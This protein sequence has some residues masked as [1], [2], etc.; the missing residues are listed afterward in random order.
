M[1]Q[2]AIVAVVVAAM[3]ATAGCASQVTPG[4]ENGGNGAS[5][6]VYISD[7]PNAIGDFEHLNVTVSKVGVHRVDD[8]DTEADE[9]GWVEKDVGN[10][11]VDLTQLTGTKAVKLTDVGLENGTYDKVFIHVSAVN[12]TLEDGS[13]PD[14]KLPSEKLHVNGEFTVG[15]GESADFVFDVGVHEA[16]GSGKY[17]V[18]PVVSES[19]P[20][21]EIEEN[22]AARQD[23]GDGAE[24]EQAGDDGTDADS[25]DTGTETQGKVSVYVS[26]E[27][28]AIDQFDHLNVTISKVGLHRAGDG[29][30]DEWV[31]KDVDARTIDLTNYLGANATK[32]TDV[33]APNGT[34]D[35]VFVYVSQVNGTLKTG[36]EVNVKLPSSKLHVDR[37]FTVGDGEQVDFVYDITVFEAGNSGKYILKPVVS[38]SGTSEQVDIEKTDEE[39]Q[40]DEDE[41]RDD[42]NEERTEAPDRALNVS[43]DGTAVAGENVTVT[44]TQNGSA[45][46]NATVKADGEAVGQTGTDG[47]LVLSVPAD[48]EELELEVE[49]GEAEGELTVAV[50]G[51]TENESGSGTSTETPTETETGALADPVL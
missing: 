2:Q 13:Q 26:D 27:E 29:G 19:G 22:P 48:A 18:K 25:D 4:G 51:D 35:K 1:N 33:D 41:E 8:P 23:S 21:K 3:L 7:E 44:V 38:E 24:N 16:G 32:L 50:E 10:V 11:T 15:D 37:E 31:E 46:A 39:E 30:D 17:V 6:S 42:E 49:R 5:V 12:G 9:S 36:E 14:V 47:T 28:N 43:L 40:R 34:Y 20:D 45:V